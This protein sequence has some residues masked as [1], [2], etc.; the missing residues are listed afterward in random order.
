MHVVVIQLFKDRKSFELS[1]LYHCVFLTDQECYANLSQLPLRNDEDSHMV[2]VIVILVLAAVFVIA[3]I[4]A[5]VKRHKIRKHFKCLKDH[6]DEIEMDNADHT[7]ENEMDNA[8]FSM[9]RERTS[10]PLLPEPNTQNNDSLPDGEGA[11]EQLLPENATNNDVS[12]NE[13]T[14][15]LIE[16]HAKD[17]GSEYIEQLE[18]NTDSPRLPKSIP[19]ITPGQGNIEDVILKKD[20][21]E[22][23]KIELES[24]FDSVLSSMKNPESMQ[25]TNLKTLVEEIVYEVIANKRIDLLT[26]FATTY[27]EE[28]TQ[29]ALYQHGANMHRTLIPIFEDVNLIL[30]I[31]KKGHLMITVKDKEAYD[32][33]VANRFRSSQVSLYVGYKFYITRA[34]SFSGAAKWMESRKQEFAK[35][36]FFYKGTDLSTIC[37]HCGCL[38]DGWAEEDDILA[39]FI[40]NRIV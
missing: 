11:T 6:T 35:F 3:V 18:E 27:E 36:G 19:Q 23:Q 34:L 25:E 9:N 26:E 14:Q 15:A 29:N 31:S 8:E 20:L 12:I 16:E 40:F 7:D 17:G 10:E 1:L 24:K 37:F 22:S 4:V 5:V 30:N 32:E 2:I 39:T 21:P 28:E 38:K 13:K 33:A